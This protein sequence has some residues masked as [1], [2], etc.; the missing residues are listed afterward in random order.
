MA[1][2]ARRVDV[3]GLVAIALV[4]TVGLGAGLASLEIA[5]RTERAY[6]DYL[7]RADVGE[8]VVNP[9]L[10]TRQV[11]GIFRSTPGVTAV[12]SDALLTATADLGP[13]ERTLDEADQNFLQVRMSDDGR[14]VDQDRPVIEDGRMARSGRE[15]FLSRA[16]A[17]ALGVGVGD[18]VRLSFYNPQIA[19]GGAAAELPPPIGRVW[20]R[21]VGIGA[22]PDEVL[23]DELWPRMKIIVSSDVGRPF[24]CHADQPARDDPRT[25]AELFAAYV[26][27]DCSTSYEFFSL[28]L[29]GG[30]AA[31]PGV[32]EALAQRFDRE[33]RQ[34]PAALREIDVGYLVIPSLRADDER[35]VRES[36]DPVVASL[37][38][39]G[40]AAGL[41]TLVLV[42][43]VVSRHLRR[44][45]DEIVVWR[46]IGAACLT[47][48]TG[49]ALA[50]LVAVGA[51]MVG[52][53]VISALIAGQGAVAS[54]S[55]LDTGFDPGLSDAVIVP[56]AAAAVLAAVAV[57]LAAWRRV[58]TSTRPTAQAAAGARSLSRGPVPVALGVRAAT[59]ARGAAAVAGAALA[60][61]TI[62]AVATFSASVSSFVTE[63]TRFAWPWDVV[64]QMNAGFGPTRLHRVEAALDDPEVA[65][66]GLV[67]MSTGFRVDGETVPFIAARRGFAGPVGAVPVVTGRLPAA[68]DE[69]ALG[70]LTAGT[71]DKAVG[72]EV[73]VTAG[74]GDRRAEVTG[75]VVLPEAGPLESDRTSL[76]NG[77]LFSGPFLEALVADGA[78][79][80]GT[81]PAGLADSM[82]SFVVIDLADGVDPEAF[83]NRLDRDGELATWD[84]GGTAPVV[85]TTPVRSP[86]V[87]DAATIQRLPWLL[88]SMFGVAMA[89]GMVAGIVA[90]VR[91][92]R[93]ELA[94]LGALGATR[95]QC[96]A[97]VRWQ[98]LVVVVAGAIV[99]A[100]VGVACGRLAYRAFAGAIGV[101]PAPTLPVPAVAVLVA[102]TAVLALATAEVAVRTGRR[103]GAQDLHRFERG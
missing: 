80:Q 19:N 39:F 75:I 18:R 13:G 74:Y 22:L 5:D 37:W 57:F 63:P 62:A 77:A 84:P 26:P 20:V 89:A 38:V 4:L 28:R 49:L 55:L 43:L 24:D 14:Y 17:E 64:A 101:V 1:R 70:A 94:I 85:H 12:T 88:G 29:A 42:V 95:G 23:P 21:V 7:R 76:G 79:A 44:R 72:D 50:P 47:S 53:L 25:V 78:A 91:A 32:V 52:A 59:G 8:L 11:E 73:E 10:R 54:A 103:R 69:I 86:V 40:L 99:G 3:L 68:D 66:W 6:P 67:A 48:M 45:R 34:L 35:R 36:L 15:A 56:S 97:T 58:A 9:S 92:R 33:N 71:L 100:P 93:H 65:A 27:P 83:V 81:T 31:A 46:A 61:S 51:G 30:E 82:G 60:I 87:I 41:A 16:V 2:V 90:A 96:R 98:A 102:G